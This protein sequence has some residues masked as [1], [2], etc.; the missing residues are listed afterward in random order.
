MTKQAIIVNFNIH[1][2][3]FTSFSGFFER[4]SSIFLGKES[5]HFA[6]AEHGDQA[7]WEAHT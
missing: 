4:H 6:E 2:L 3:P 5:V 1:F 7:W